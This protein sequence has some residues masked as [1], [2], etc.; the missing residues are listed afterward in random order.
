MI[1]VKHT[2]MVPLNIV[3][4][5]NISGTQIW[6]IHRE[7]NSLI[8]LTNYA[9]PRILCLANILFSGRPTDVLRTEINHI[10]SSSFE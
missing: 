4:F 10:G 5:V 6:T 1:I 3:I 7:L 2:S 9:K 8:R